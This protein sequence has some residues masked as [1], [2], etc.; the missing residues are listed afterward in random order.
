MARAHHKIQST[1]GERNANSPFTSQRG[2]LSLLLLVLLILSGLAVWLNADAL[3]RWQYEKM[4]TAQLIEQARAQTQ[5]AILAQVAGRRCLQENTPEKATEF[6]DS[7]LKAHPQNA[8][9][10]LLAG[11]VAWLT[12]DPQRAGTLLN[13]A[14]QADPTNP[15]NLYWTGEL[16]IDRGRKTE[17]F[18]LWHD[19]IRLDPTRGDI[20]TRIGQ[21]QLESQE[22]QS[23][24]QALDEAEKVSPTATV[25]RLRAATLL[26]MDRADE[27]EKAARL[28]VQRQPNAASYRLLGQII[29]Q[30]GDQ[31][32]LREAQNNFQ[33]A[34]K[35]EPHDVETLRLLALNYRALGEHAQAVKVLRTLLHETPALTE[36][37]LLLGQ[38]YQALGDSERA[39]Q[40]LRIFRQ[41]QP[42]QEKVNRARQ[43]VS[44]EHGT[45]ASELN[46]ARALLAL[47]RIDLAR[48]VLE[49][50][51]SKAPHNAKIRELA[52]QAQEPP[53]SIPALPSDPSAEKGKAGN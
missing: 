25:A 37:Y 46:Y 6:L 19:A 47:G 26:E 3:R 27:A 17:A 18:S 10:N 48:E 24:L 16:L 44:I 13:T 30:T 15:E 33:R 29:Q 2:K 31:N 36:G 9:L 50:A 53:P 32:R 1:V 45:L 28:A 41:L 11:R 34:L 5:N 14:L 51:W 12:G 8:E 42:L 43:R 39:A 38:S 23:S 35:D 20:W 49:R 21:I 52:N 4:P 40:V 22:F 7:A